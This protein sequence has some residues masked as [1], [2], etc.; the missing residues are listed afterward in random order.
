MNAWN[1]PAAFV[2]RGLEAARQPG[3]EHL[4][5]RDVGERLHVGLGEHA[6]REQA[7]LDDQVRVRPGEVAQ[8]L[9]RGDGVALTNAIATG[10]SSSGSHVLEPGV[11]RRPAGPACS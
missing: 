2:E 11:L 4:A 10:P 5:G 3:E 1:R 8:R 9:G 6:I 7:A